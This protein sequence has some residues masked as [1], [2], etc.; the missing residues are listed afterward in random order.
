MLLPQCTIITP[1]LK[2][3]HVED[4]SD[5][6]LHNEEVR[7]VDVELDRPEQVLH[8]RGCGIAPIDQ[9]L[10]ATTNH[11]LHVRGSGQE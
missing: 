11:N 4:L 1:Y 2:R 6:S 5:P 9:V 3:L 7:V 10:I 8:S